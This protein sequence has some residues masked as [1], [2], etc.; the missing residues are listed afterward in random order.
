V[1][2][3]DVAVGLAGMLVLLSSAFGMLSGFLLRVLVA[4]GLAT[5]D[6]GAIFLALSFV[7]LASI[8]C[9]LGLNQGV[10]KFVAERDSGSTRRRS[11]TMLALTL[12]L[13]ASLL[14]ISLGFLTRDLIME[15]FF[16]DGVSPRFLYA[17]LFAF[18][19]Y[20][21]GKMSTSVLR[22]MMETK[23]F[24]FVDQI[25][26]PLAKVG[27][28]AVALVVFGTALAVAW[29]LALAFVIVATL[30]F[31]FLLAHGWRPTF[32]VR[33]RLRPLLGFS[34]PLMVSSSVFILIT[35]A[36][37]ILIGYFSTTAAVGRYEVAMSLALLLGVFHSAFAFL[38]FPKVSELSKAERGDEI[39]QMYQQITKWIL[40]FTTPPFLILLFR[41]QL[42]LSLFG[43]QYLGT[44]IRVPLWILALGLFS[45]AILGPN[46]QTLAGF[47][48][49]KVLLLYNLAAATVNLVLNIAL[50]PEFGI[51]G[52]ALASA[53]GYTGMNL[54]KSVD[55]FVNHDVRIAGWRAILMA[56]GS[57]IVI[58]PLL[59]FFPEPAS[60]LLELVILAV[61]GLISL[62]V[63][64]TTLY[65]VGGVTDADRDLVRP[66]MEFVNR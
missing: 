35:G 19:F 57:G 27:F 12:S 8:P 65:Y 63:G 59:L 33:E 38:L 60:L 26:R 51:V 40:G 29:G 10:V 4:R 52:A 13:L 28:A 37:R 55:L 31:K 66:L 24:V 6:F 17:F 62:G 58:V 16:E 5:S 43:D 49:S 21:T 20:V 2:S 3:D 44:G 22:G 42:L 64:A 9:L 23:E 54:M 11:D 30:G 25:V 56:T 32:R 1:T 53:I 46:G 45:H 14:A 50:I 15:T 36:D 48:R 39:P 18:P 61:A 34:L 7:N 47:G 41:P